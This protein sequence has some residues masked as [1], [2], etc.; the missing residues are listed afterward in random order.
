MKILITGCR[1]YIGHNLIE[2][3]TRYES[4]AQI[5]GLD[6]CSHTDSRSRTPSISYIPD[7]IQN[8]KL[9][10][11]VTHVVHLAGRTGVHPSWDSEM[12]Q[13]YFDDNVVASKKIFDTYTDIPVLYATSS[14][15]KELR[16]PYSM[17]KATVELIAP[18]NAIGMRFYTVYGGN[19]ARSDMFYGRALNRN[20][21]TI[22]TNKRDWT[23]M[24]YVCKAIHAILLLGE[25]GKI[26]DVGKGNPQTP[27]EFLD[28]MG[29]NIDYPI[30][31]MPNESQETCAD[32][33]EINQLLTE[34]HIHVNHS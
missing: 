34:Y 29:I 3:L 9:P 27:R 20:I 4:D 8:A 19:L 18:K 12:L 10:E 1:G 13:K 23:R 15:V 21:R 22:S 33:S 5:V 26:Y 28:Q 24:D 14:A 2:F 16:S 25:P 17:T 31:D 11:D 7:T 32:P 30:V 6:S